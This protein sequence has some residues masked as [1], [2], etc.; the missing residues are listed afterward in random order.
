MNQ[1]TLPL[2]DALV[3]DASVARLAREL[4]GLEDAASLYFQEFVVRGE[5]RYWLL[6]TE[7]IQDLKVSQA[8]YVLKHL[9]WFKEQIM[10]AA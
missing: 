4:V 8:E 6:P 5:A 3:S 1:E 9:A 10:G 7:T 2:L